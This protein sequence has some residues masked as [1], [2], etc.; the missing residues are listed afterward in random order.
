MIQINITDLTQ[1]NIYPVVLQSIEDICD[2]YNLNK[3]FGFIST[4]CQEVIEHLLSSGNNFAVN[5]DINIENTELAFLFTS[6]DPVF[7]N[8]LEHY[9]EENIL[10][11]LT[12]KLDI[13]SENKSVSLTFHVKTHCEVSRAFTQRENVLKT[14]RRHL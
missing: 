4:A 10:K 8:L 1:E 5:L 2:E 3:E 11:D 14:E 7:E 13:S 12:D 6:S 9:S